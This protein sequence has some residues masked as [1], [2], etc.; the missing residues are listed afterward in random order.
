MLKRRMWP[1]VGFVAA[2]AVA[3]PAAWAVGWTNVGPAGVH[4]NNIV[5]HRVG[6]AN[7]VYSSQMRLYV[8]TH[9]P[10]G[11]PNF[12]MGYVYPNGSQFY[13]YS[14]G[15]TICTAAETPSY[16]NVDGGNKFAI[17]EEVTTEPT[18]PPSTCQRY[19]TT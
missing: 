9:S 6:T 5:N 14:T 15:R 19:S 2:L 1:F 13:A 16:W 4:L 12:H 7:P 3:V 17:C 11:G 8:Q 18:D 10:C